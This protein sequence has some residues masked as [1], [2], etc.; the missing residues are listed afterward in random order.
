MASNAS[1]ITEIMEELVF[2]KT[3]LASI[4]DTVADRDD[5]EEEIRGEIRKLEKRLKEL[6][7]GTSG[8]H[9]ASQLSLAASPNSPLKNASQAS[10]SAAMEG[11]QRPEGHPQS[12]ADSMASTPNSADLELLS[13]SRMN[14]PTRKRTH[15]TH[16]DGGLAP[17]NGDSKS[18]RTTPSPYMTSPSTPAISISSGDDEMDELDN[19]LTQ[20]QKAEEDRRVQEKLDEEFART[21]QNEPAVFQSMAPPPSSARNAFSRMSGVRPSLSA[22]SS[23]SQTPQLGPSSARKLPWGLPSQSSNAVKPEPH[24][25]HSRVKPESSSMAQQMPGSFQ[26]DSSDANDSDIEIIPASAFRDN[27]RHQNYSRPGFLSEYQI[28]GQAQGNDALHTA[29]Y[30]SASIPDWASSVSASQNS[31]YTSSMNSAGPSGMG[32]GMGMN[33]YGGGILPNSSSL[34]NGGPSNPFGTLNSLNNI[35][36]YPGYSVNGLPP[37]PGFA[38]P[39]NNVPDSMMANSYVYTSETQP[40]ESFA[41]IIQRTG[42]SFENTTGY[43]NPYSFN[44]QMQEQANYIINDP[45]KTNDEIKELLENIRPDLDLPAENREGTPEGMTYGL[46]EHQKLAL[47]WL[48][49]MEDGS[50]KGGILADDMGLGKTISAL[51]L[52]LSRPSDNPARKTTLIV[53]P[54]ALVRQWQ[55]EIRTK[56]KSSHRLSA[57]LLHGAPASA[58]H[59]DTIQTYDVVLTTYGTLGAEF[60]RLEKYMAEQRR[61]GITD[62]DSGAMKKLFP[63][64]GPRSIF[65]RIFL[66]EAQCIKNKNTIAA[67]GACSVKATFRFCLTGT[68]MMNNVGELYSLIH[69][70]RIKPY[71]E[72]NRFNNEFGMLT[73]GHATKRDVS[74]AMKRLQAVI[75]AILLRRTKTSKIDGKP[76]ITLPPKS[77]EIQ[78]VVFDEDELAFYK[79]LETKTQI[80]FNKFVK[81]GTVGKN[82]SN[83]LVLLLR[84]RQCCCHPH[85]ITDFEEAPPAGVD[86]SAETMLELARN[87]QPEVVARL[88]AANG[89]F[90]CPVCYDAIE[91]PS[92]VIPCGH[93]TCAECL[94]KISDQA[95]VN[96]MANGEEARAEAKCPTCRG[97]VQLNKIIDYSSFK[98][99]HDPDPNAVDEEAVA[100]ESSDDS[101]SESDSGSETES[102]DDA[103]SDGDLRDFIVPDNVSDIDN[104]NDPI[105][106]DDE[107]AP[108]PRNAKSKHGKTKGK[109]K[110]KKTRKKDKG[111]KKEKKEHVS[112]AVLKKEASKSAKGRRKYMKFLDERWQDSAKI[113][114]CVELLDQF[115]QEGEKTIVFSQ[116]VSLLDL[117]QVQIS[118]KNWKCERYDGS[119]SADARNSAIETFT[120]KADSRIMLISLKA[121][122]AGL[123]LTAASRVIILDP[124]WNPYIEMQAIDRAY[125]I[126]QQRSVQVHR[127]L[128]EGTVED[129][130][131][132]LQEQK[133]KLVDAALDEGANKSLGRLDVRQLAYLFGV[134]S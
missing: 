2:Q 106:D 22:T 123:N 69:F 41:D 50:N 55:K 92:I 99:V 38:N 76:I 14:L 65:Y 122:N 34:V 95:Q 124:F 97:K 10:S 112:L 53:G 84:L 18:R 43:N 68:P 42:S 96:N 117:L 74:H 126:G 17:G 44:E 88:I 49:S 130:I 108:A 77:E 75:R 31:P 105:E 94:S 90:E 81:A 25:M 6:K 37:G 54:V 30:G 1:Q 32:M 115:Q 111:K 119:M 40:L 102:G 23:S 59:W 52:I 125:R 87:L 113:T 28:P 61:T 89:A 72:W 134:G 20:R 24:S 109:S 70:L 46:Y 9:P 86:I 39:S 67:R 82:Y 4:D 79:A 83:V 80:Q 29:M 47:T 26:E 132:E 85:L 127:I 120:D 100:N 62:L 64:L 3:M 110:E 45:R 66:D 12:T 19:F 13:P 5:A 16:I 21:L 60:K 128:V 33:V 63:I 104:E 15:S 101:D 78:H 118:R 35:G 11:Y 8:R 129:R 93:D 91:N 56:I 27:G 57:L 7:R 98:K 73:K 116:F 51:A 107:V 36:M 131:V 58:K 71:N 114:K 121:G 48:K 133:R 103:N